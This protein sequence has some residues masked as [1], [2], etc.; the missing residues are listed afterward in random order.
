MNA[1]WVSGM[2]RS[3]PRSIPTYTYLI[4]VLWRP[5]YDSARNRRSYS[6][7][8]GHMNEADV[9]PGVYRRHRGG[10]H[11]E[12]RRLFP[13]TQVHRLIFTRAFHRPFACPCI[14][15]ISHSLLGSI[16][17]A[18]R[19]KGLYGIGKV[20][21]MGKIEQTLGIGPVHRVQY[22]GLPKK[23]TILGR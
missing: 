21:A 18:S 13:Y 11:Q 12:N 14:D 23:K 19:E 5:Y 22:L 1:K 8:A 9:T 7:L 17:F 6:G 2:K 20:G 4:L 3:Q 10:G 15:T 16:L